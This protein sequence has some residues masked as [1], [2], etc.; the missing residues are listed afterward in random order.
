M[1]TVGHWEATRQS[2]ISRGVHSASRVPVGYDKAAD[3][4]LVPNEYAGIVQ[5]AF[6]MR[7]EDGASWRQIA[8]YFVAE[9]LPGG[10]WPTTSVQAVLRNRVYLGEARFGDQVK[11]GAHPAL[12]DERTFR[13]ANRRQ[14]STHDRTPSGFLL[15][16]GL[17]RCAID[18]AGMVRG[19]GVSGG[20]PY[21]FLRCRHGG[22]SPPHP[23][24][25]FTKIEPYVRLAF[26]ERVYERRDPDPTALLKPAMDKLVTAVADPQ[27]LQLLENVHMDIR[28]LDRLLE[29]G[30]LPASIYAKAM[31][32]AQRD[33]ESL[34][35]QIAEAPSEHPRWAVEEDELRYHALNALSALDE[36]VPADLVKPARQLLSE[37]LGTI[38]VHPG[39]GPVDQRVSF[40]RALKARAAM[41]GRGSPWP[42]P[43]WVS[44]RP[45][46][47]PAGLTHK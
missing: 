12:V 24:I 2:L 11:V 16:G 25:S 20:R 41:T 7:A 42:V 18:G 32:V 22:G 44:E 26:V 10:K 4:R 43:G 46:S 8:R 13:L 40:S 31:T 5:E 1:L 28:E 6:R 30:G 21:E 27:L 23:T 38:A 15:G 47:G 34:E 17:V 14:S 9:G 33:K 39:R 3:K 45:Y 37:V 19:K 35:A 29:E 36:P